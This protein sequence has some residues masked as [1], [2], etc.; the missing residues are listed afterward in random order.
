MAG[1]LFP[2]NG[3][4][5]SPFGWRSDVNPLA[6]R[7][8][9]TGIDFGVPT[10]TAVRATHSGRVDYDFQATGGGNMVLLYGDAGWRTVYAHLSR[11]VPSIREGSYVHQG[12]IIGYSGATGNVTG[13]HLHYEVDRRRNGVWTPLDP[14]YALPLSAGR[15]DV[16]WLRQSGFRYDADTAARQAARQ[17]GDIRR[18]EMAARVYERQSARFES[19][20]SR[21]I[22]GE[23][24][25][26]AATQRRYGI[27]TTQ[28]IPRFAS[29]QGRKAPRFAT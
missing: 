4:I 5:T 18:A 2:V 24:A 12:Q 26:I 9:H 22:I 10:G 29:S 6:A 16:G 19:S 27:D 25:E 28:R 1:L 14:R 3:P 21:G 11:Y 20:Q 23:Y 8:F 15:G 13:A 17:L 7:D